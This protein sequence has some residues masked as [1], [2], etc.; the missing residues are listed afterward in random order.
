MNDLVTEY[1]F[2][3]VAMETLGSWGP[4]GLKFITEIGDILLSVTD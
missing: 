3:L 2:I 1:E 4:S